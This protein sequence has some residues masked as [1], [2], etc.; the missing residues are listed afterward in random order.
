MY[1]WDFVA[2][3]HASKDN[4]TINKDMFFSRR[5]LL[6][7]RAGHS[8]VT[9]CQHATVSLR[10]SYAL[11]ERKLPFPLTSTPPTAGRQKGN[12]RVWAALGLRGGV[13]WDRGCVISLQRYPF[14]VPIPNK[15]MDGMR[16]AE[17]ACTVCA[18]FLPSIST[19]ASVP[20]MRTTSIAW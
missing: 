13:C 14:P 6:I 19:I 16:L 9:H 8:W 4:N 10:L 1:Y 18:L 11:V 12:A 20:S 3:D 7:L 2:I 15:P 5:T 17:C